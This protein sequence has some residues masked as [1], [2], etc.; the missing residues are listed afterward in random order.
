MDISEH[1]IIG[2]N[3]TTNCLLSITKIKNKN[4]NKKNNKTTKKNKENENA[5][6]ENA[7]QN[8]LVVNCYTVFAT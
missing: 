1:V 2:P 6:E 7:K 5:I 8:I 3:I 4:K